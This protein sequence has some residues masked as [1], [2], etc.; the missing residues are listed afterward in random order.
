QRQAFWS[1]LYIDLGIAR[2]QFRLQGQ[3][4]PSVI[5]QSKYIQARTSELSN[6]EVSAGQARAADHIADKPLIVLTAGRP[7][8]SALRAALSAQDC[9]AYQETW[10]NDLQVRLVHLSTKG[11]RVIVADTGHHIPGERPDAIVSAVRELR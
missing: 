6:I 9:A 2:L 11:K 10:I 3:E 5:L 8:D 7:V 4:V 1:P